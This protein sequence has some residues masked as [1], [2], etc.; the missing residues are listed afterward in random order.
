MYAPM[1]DMKCL[2]VRSDEAHSFRDKYFREAG[3]P[4][5]RNES[6]VQ[7]EAQLL[8]KRARVSGSF[9]GCRCKQGCPQRP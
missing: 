5:G 6:F 2:C 9:C 1:A 3:S 7:E 4:E 8:R